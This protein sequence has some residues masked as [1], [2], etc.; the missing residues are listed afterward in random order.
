[1]AQSLYP[2]QFDRLMG[3]VRFIA[4]VLGRTMP[5]ARG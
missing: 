4:P 3:E 2:D 1:V 5:L